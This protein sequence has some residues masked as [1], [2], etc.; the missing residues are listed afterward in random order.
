MTTPASAP[1]TAPARGRG[2]R[3]RRRGRRRRIGDR[4]GAR[5]APRDG[6]AR[7]ATPGPRRVR[8]RRADH[9]QPAAPAIV[10]TSTRCGATSAT[11]STRAAPAA[12]CRRRELS[13]RRARGAARVS[14]L[15]LGQSAAAGPSTAAGSPSLRAGVAVAG[16]VVL[17]LNSQ[18]GRWRARVRRRRDASITWS[19]VG[20]GLFAWW[21]RPENRVGPLMI[22][23]GFSWVPERA[24]RLG[25]ARRVHHRRAAQQRLDRAPVP[26]A[27]AFPD[28]RLQTRT[29]RLLAAAAWTSTAY[30]CRCR[31]SCSSTSR[32]R[33]AAMG[34][35]PTRC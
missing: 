15:G 22:A 32:T 24:L 6:P 14:A 20:T 9:R 2:L 8:R 17:M 25:D 7:R 1:R 4:G 19:F 31:R 23:V 28:G 21:R 34:A 33:I 35:L 13:G 26:D 30:C 29:E 3:G 27:A 16:G 12:S 11:W 18:R 5:A 10:L